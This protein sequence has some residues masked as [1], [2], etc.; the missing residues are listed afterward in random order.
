MRVFL[1]I[2][3]F[4][5]EQLQVLVEISRKT[6]KTRGYLHMRLKHGDHFT[7]FKLSHE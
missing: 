5:G 4:T 6:E 1:Q 3:F 2:F 7:N